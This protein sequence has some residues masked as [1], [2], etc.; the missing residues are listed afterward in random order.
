MQKEFKN[1]FKLSIAFLVVL[2]FFSLTRL[3]FYLNNL[4]VFSALPDFNLSDAFV[5]GFIYDVKFVLAVNSVI[6]L[7]FFLPIRLR[8]T[9]FWQFIVKLSFTLLNGALIL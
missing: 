3:Y 4:A 2:V 7:M 8:N 9:I 1:L 6:I 5:Y